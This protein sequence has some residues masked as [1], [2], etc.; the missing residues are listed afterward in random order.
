MTEKDISIDH[1]IPWSYV[2]HDELWNLSSTTRSINSRKSNSLPDW[3]F[4]FDRLCKIEYQSYQ[5]VRKH[6]GVHK[7]FERCLQEHVNSMDVRQKLYR[8]G[9]SQEEFTNNLKVL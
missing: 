3:G 8:D 5:A 6:V 1:F 7:E 9:L 2:A 4:Y